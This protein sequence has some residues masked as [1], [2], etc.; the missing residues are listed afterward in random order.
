MCRLDRFS[1]AV[2]RLGFLVPPMTLG[3]GGR[4]L[5]ASFG[6]GEAFLEGRKQVRL[7]VPGDGHANTRREKSCAEKPHR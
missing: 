1:S 2:F 3:A 4:T 6:G 7:S 5:A